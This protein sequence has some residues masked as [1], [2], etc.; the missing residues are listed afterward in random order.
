MNST[1]RNIVLV[2]VWLG[3][4]RASV[5]LEFAP[6]ASIWF[7]SAGL[8][9]AALLV[10]GWRAVF[11]IAVAGFVSTAWIAQ[12]YNE[13]LTVT[14][15]FNSSLLFVLAHTIPLGLGAYIVRNEYRRNG[16][17]GFARTVLI[18]LVVAALSAM[19]TSFFGILAIWEGGLMTQ[20]Q[21]WLSWLPW[22]IGDMAGIIVLA[23]VFIAIVSWRYHQVQLEL[24]ELNFSLTAINWKKFV[25]RLVL[26]LGLLL[27]SLTLVHHSQR[28]EASF[29]VFFII[30]PFLWIATTTSQLT[31]VFILAIFS[32][33]LAFLVSQL[34]VIDFA[35]VY[36]FAMITTAGC[37]WF[38]LTIPTLMTQ[39]AQLAQ[40]VARDGL[41][42][43]ASR[44]HFIQRLEAEL[45]RSTPN[46]TCC[47][48]IFDFDF[49]KQINDRHGHIL[50][51]RV[52]VSVTNYVS[53]LLRE[54]D[55][56]GRFGG[57]EFMLMFPATEFSEA[58]VIAKRL[59]TGISQLTI[60]GL[61]EPVTCSFGVVECHPSE[62]AVSAIDR[63]DRA[64]LL[65]KQRGRR[66]VVG[67]A[68]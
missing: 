52:L 40:R 36:Q 49:F 30:L 51:D 21:P 12:I 62:H 42:K 46:S 41:T 56:M 35:L 37:V 45:Q 7:P 17:N 59:C 23:P 25:S 38:A 32:T 63:A 61:D 22:W 27:I 64:L 66:Q 57:D 29:T 10:L 34:H 53:Q 48:V 47:L 13:P 20:A 28:I 11:P 9:F 26:V 67:S 33:V 68:A 31:T 6:H 60:D 1:V 43:A 2:I 14:G 19:L 5:L 18:F 50:G 8:S 39:N 16:I 4:W 24:G 58:Q 55:I 15:W 65:A 3:L 44:G 54:N